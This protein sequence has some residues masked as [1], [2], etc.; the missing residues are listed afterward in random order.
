MRVKLLFWVMTLAAF[1]SACKKA[2]EGFFNEPRQ[3]YELAVEGGINTLTTGQFIR[4]MKPSTHPDSSPEPISNAKVSVF[5]GTA[6]L[7]FREST[8]GLYTATYRRT[9]NYN[10]A[11]KLTISYNGKMY[12]AVDTLRQLVNIVDDFLP[13]SARA[14]NGKIA[15][16]IPKHTFGYLNPNKWMITYGNIPFWNP[17]RFDQ[18][19]YYSYTH[20]LGSPNSLYPLDNL[21]REFLLEPDE[22]VTIYKISLS[23]RYARFLYSTFMET[24]WSGLFSGVPVNISGNISGNAQG[25]FSVCDVDFSRYRAKEL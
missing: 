15:G 16:T 23:E 20:L 21:K 18:N 3:P 25:Y 8:P 4:L 11:Y 7:V 6:D 13:L 19:R 2:Q 5:D 10:G 9:P 14:V 1:L 17:S 24:D 22:Y 12:T